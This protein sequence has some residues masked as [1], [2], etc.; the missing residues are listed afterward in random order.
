[1]EFKRKQRVLRNKFWFRIIIC[2][3]SLLGIAFYLL[4]KINTSLWS[5]IIGVC[6][7][8]LVWSLVELVDFIIQT[9]YQYESERNTFFGIISNHFCKMKTIIREND[10]EIPMHDLKKIVNELY[11]ETN[12]FIF[13]SNIYPIS[14]EFEMC[15]NYIERMYWKFYSCCTGI[16]ENCEEKTEY[17]KK[18]YDAILLVKED[19]ELTS[20]R[21]FDG[22]S[23]QKR[24]NEMIDIELS[25]EKYNLPENLLKQDITGNIKECFTVPG[26]IR[27]TTT[28]I[29]DLDFQNFYI[30]GKSNAL[31]VCICLLFRKIRTNRIK[32]DGLNG[33]KNKLKDFFQSQK[34]ER[35]C[36]TINK[37]VAVIVP[38]L[39]VIMYL[40]LAFGS[41]N[42]LKNYTNSFVYVSLIM[43]V[44]LFP[45]SLS[46]KLNTYAQKYSWFCLII[47]IFLS[48]CYAAVRV[49]CFPNVKQF[50]DFL[51][52]IMILFS[53][54]VLINKKKKS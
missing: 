12:K 4:Y 28:F 52:A 47:V 45:F 46:K 10:N 38:I 6:G 41:S 34:W 29:P 21:F 39:M 37:I 22:L 18:L 25:F 33:G 17:Y 16:Y 43:S 35:I 2:I 5:I 48:F 30:S 23:S 15:S 42:G 36:N 13:S 40:L 19:Q 44:L 51:T 24:I 9:H 3:L 31:F 53:Y 26:N 32:L 20:K 54:L 27:K 8:A 1:M 50:E 7:S 14:K 11:D 49:Q